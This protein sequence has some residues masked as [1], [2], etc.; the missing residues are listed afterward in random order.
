MI[1]QSLG[2]QFI[3]G[4]AHELKEYDVSEGR[5]RYVSNDIKYL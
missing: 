2:I 4:S 1:S 5:T 3:F